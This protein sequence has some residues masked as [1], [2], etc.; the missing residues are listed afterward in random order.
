M[1]D[2]I[3]YGDDIALLILMAVAVYDDFSTGHIPNY[4]ILSGSSVGIGIHVIKSGPG[5]VAYSLTGF[6]L[7]FVLLFLLHI[8]KMTG[9][10]DVKLLMMAGTY[11]GASRILIA[12]V[13][14]FVT[15]A[16]VSL[17]LMIKYGIFF[18]R[19]RY[20]TQYIYHIGTTRKIFPYY[21]FKQKKKGETLHFS[22]YIFLGVL[23]SLSFKY[24]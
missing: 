7:P 5:G 3:L 9:A 4:L 1:C 12:I 19:L 20:F 22:L 14:A 13:A 11:I 17:I 6:I 18:E 10:G 16:A 8:L 21:D 24:F 23:F 15:A 2:F